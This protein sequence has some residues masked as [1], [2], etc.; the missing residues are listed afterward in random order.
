VS[1]EFMVGDGR[2]HLKTGLMGES[3][4]AQRLINSTDIDEEVAILPHVKLVGLGGRSIFDRGRA[5]VFPLVDQ[6]VEARKAHDLVVG[7][8]GG[9][10]VRHVY[11]IGLDL[12]LPTG[13]LAQL[14]GACEEQNATMLQTLLAKHKGVKLV[15]DHFPDLP[16]YL[17]HGMIPIVI[18]VPPYHHWEPPSRTGRL[19]ENGSDLGFYMTAE[20]L[21][22]RCCIFIKDQD[23]LYTDDPAKNA[24]AE[25]IPRI[26]AAELME[27]NLPSLIL[28]RTVVE[29]LQN[30][31]FVREIQIVNGLVPGNLLKALNGE[32]VGTIIHR[33]DVT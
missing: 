33:E 8:S 11:Q 31:R 23:G 6:L 7:V 27:R 16:L 20:A 1:K 18:S 21:G 28:D 5:A 14:V 24:A 9:A 25:F 29:T 19:P 30:A 12:G 13:G 32:H 2:V 10:R 26:G 3:L 15:R 4:V 22:A 17:E